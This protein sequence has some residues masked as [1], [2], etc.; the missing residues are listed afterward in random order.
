[1]SKLIKTC[2][3]CG[4]QFST[5]QKAQL[6]CSRLCAAEGRAVKLAGKKFG[7]LEC[8]SVARTKAGSRAWACVCECG[9]KTT[10]SVAGLLSGQ[11]VSCGCYHSDMMRAHMGIVG[12]NNRKHK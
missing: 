3:H 11:T 1:M 6:F 7:R 2:A 10:V 4:K 9:N 8:I 5:Y 12:R